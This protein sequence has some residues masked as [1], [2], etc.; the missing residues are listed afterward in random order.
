MREYNE[1]QNN[2]FVYF[3]IYLLQSPDDWIRQLYSQHARVTH[4]T[5]N[6]CFETLS[7]V[8]VDPG[9]SSR[10]SEILVVWT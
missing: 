3:F 8:A 6:T 1:T 5:W 7:S 4:N 9:I 10:V 2:F